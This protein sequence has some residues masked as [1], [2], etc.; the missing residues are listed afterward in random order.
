ML[1]ALEIQKI[2]CTAPVLA[3]FQVPACIYSVPLPF[4]IQQLLVAMA[5]L[6]AIINAKE[7]EEQALMAMERKKKTQNCC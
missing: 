7:A 2:A 6:Q 3:A 4:R 5:A 1:K